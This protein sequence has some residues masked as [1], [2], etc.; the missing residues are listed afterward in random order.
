MSEEKPAPA[1]VADELARM[2]REEM[3]PVEKKLV[4]WSL[5]LGVT[6]LAALTWLSKLLFPS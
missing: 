4:F 1:N 5:L 2:Q 3:L 6:L